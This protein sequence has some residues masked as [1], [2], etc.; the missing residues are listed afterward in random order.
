MNK[1]NVCEHGIS[2]ASS[3]SLMVFWQ[4][5]SRAGIEEKCILIKKLIAITFR[6]RSYKCIRSTCRCNSFHF[7]QC[8]SIFG[9]LN[10]MHFAASSCQPHV[11]DQVRS[12]ADER[13][14][15]YSLCAQSQI[16]NC[17]NE[18]E[19]LMMMML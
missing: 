3:V 18:D 4:L 17:N 2:V 12:S 15:P 10:S 5:I 13:L 1:W 19:A 16:L 6:G 8:R 9:D 14:I 11:K 7:T